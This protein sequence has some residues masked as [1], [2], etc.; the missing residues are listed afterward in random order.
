MIAP[1]VPRSSSALSP[2]L[3]KKARPSPGYLTAALTSI[4]N[5]HKQS[6]IGELIPWNHSGRTDR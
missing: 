5:R 1:T 6:R 3:W 2:S 4:V